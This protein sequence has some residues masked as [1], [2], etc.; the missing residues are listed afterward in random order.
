MHGVEVITT[1]DEHLR[2]EP[3]LL[4]TMARNVNIRPTGEPVLGVPGT[5]TVAEED[6][7]GCHGVYPR[8][9]RTLVQL[10]TSS[11]A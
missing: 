3:C 6:D 10:S 2:C 7:A 1:S 11:P 9:G 8:A 5:L 4:E